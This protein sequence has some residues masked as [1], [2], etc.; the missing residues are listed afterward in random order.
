M[1]VVILG[2]CVYKLLAK[3]LVEEPVPAPFEWHAADLGRPLVDL[4]DKEAIRR[5]LDEDS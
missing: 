2:V 3:A 5:V 4:E 1:G